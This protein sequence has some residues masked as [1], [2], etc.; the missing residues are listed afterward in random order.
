MRY[1]LRRCLYKE[2]G[3]GAIAAMVSAGCLCVKN[4]VFGLQGGEVVAVARFISFNSSPCL[5][6]PP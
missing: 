1:K 6:A 5:P 4:W 2:A 3:A